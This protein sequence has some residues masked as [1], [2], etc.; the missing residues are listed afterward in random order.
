MPNFQ[1][2]YV[3]LFNKLKLFHIVLWLIYLNCKT[4]CLV[5]FSECV[6]CSTFKTE[7]PLDVALF[8]VLY[9]KTLIKNACVFVTCG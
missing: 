9:F 2:L 5:K 8:N 3:Y 4:V 7:V 6:S 1:V